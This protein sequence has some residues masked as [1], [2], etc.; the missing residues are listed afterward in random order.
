M[1]YMEIWERFFYKRSFE[2][3]NLPTI[4][5]F[6]ALIVGEIL[7]AFA[8][9]SVIVLSR[10]IKNKVIRG[11]L[12][13]I[14]CLFV[15]NFL[16]S[17]VMLVDFPINELLIQLFFLV[18]TI[19]LI[20]YRKM[21]K[22]LIKIVLVSFPF[23]LIIFSQAVLGVVNNKDKGE[24]IQTSSLFITRES[25]PRVLW[26]VFDEADYRI[27]FEK[28][29]PNLELQALDQFR[30]E[31][32]QAENAY[33]P[34]GSTIDTM[35]SII[36]GRI[37]TGHKWLNDSVEL[38]YVDSLIPRIWGSQPNIFTKVKAL[39]MNSA[40]FGYL[41]YNKTIRKDVMFCDWSSDKY[42]YVSPN[43]TFLA[44]LGSQ[45]YGLLAFKNLSL[46]QHRIAYQEIYHA[47]QRLVKDQQYQLVL[48]HFSIPHLPSIGHPAWQGN[49][50]TPKDYEENLLIVD[51]TFAN[52]RKIMENEGLWDNTN[53]I[54]SSD[55][56][57]RKKQYIRDHKIDHRVPFILKLTG[58]NVNIV[59]KPA[60][61]TILTHELILAL[62]RKEIITERDLLKWFEDHR[63]RYPI[64]TWGK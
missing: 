14:F 24:I 9:W 60:F 48:I 29:P 6:L 40:V 3:H 53:I 43:D 22:S 16:Y 8:I 10:K 26:L 11:V 35:P 44:N 28:R 15:I 27:M 51:Q 47:A 23:V 38:T 31:A 56:W 52:L 17:L 46:V 32:F 33:P 20:Y 42:D 39:K 18:A 62:L 57:L 59:Y 41:P 12:K 25:T 61:N 30:Q 37:V 13:C 19:L 63:E 2:V 1:A 58:Q 21:T 55:H 34:G 49:Y 5:S 50:H 4:N 64:N 45:F 36:D 54:V 7:I